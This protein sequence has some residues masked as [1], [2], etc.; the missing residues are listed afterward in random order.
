MATKKKTEHD[1]WFENLLAE[2]RKESLE[3]GSE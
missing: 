3:K 2:L 1:K